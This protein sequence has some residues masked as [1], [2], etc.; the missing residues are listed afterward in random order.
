MS[1]HSEHAANLHLVETATANERRAAEDRRYWSI[2]DAGYKAR[3][4]INFW[5]GIGLM[6]CGLVEGSFLTF[7]LIGWF[8]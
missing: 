2:F 7:F 1:R 8:Q 4:T 5:V 3:G 6:A